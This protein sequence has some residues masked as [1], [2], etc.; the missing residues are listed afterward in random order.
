M[1]TSV[2]ELR[3]LGLVCSDRFGQDRVTD[4]VAWQRPSVGVRGRGESVKVRATAQAARAAFPPG[5]LCQQSAQLHHDASES[6]EVGRRLSSKGTGLGIKRL[7]VQIPVRAISLSL[8]P[9]HY[10]FANHCRHISPEH[11]QKNVFLFFFCFVF[12]F[13][14]FTTLTLTLTLTWTIA[15]CH[16]F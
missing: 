11:S 4:G 12:S 3:T 1:Y 15:L 2:G 5:L 8:S 14:I 16:T 9:S 7:Q 10:N 13:F 6:Q